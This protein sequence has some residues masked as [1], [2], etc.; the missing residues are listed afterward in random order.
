MA[1]R[2]GLSPSYVAKI[3]RGESH[4]AR[5]STVADVATRLRLPRSFFEDEAVAVGEWRE[6]QRS[7][8]AA[9]R[10]MVAAMFEQD[11]NDLE[12]LG[13]AHGLTVRQFA[14]RLLELAMIGDRPTPAM[15]RLLARTVLESRAL[16]LVQRVLAA[17]ATAFD[18]ESFGSALALALVHDVD[19]LELKSRRM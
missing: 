10:G 14:E 19:P 6:H 4:V 12:A 8:E 5:E 7:E 13:A 11:P 3:T 15:Y 1:R 16:Q 18:I 17:D 2:L 9:V